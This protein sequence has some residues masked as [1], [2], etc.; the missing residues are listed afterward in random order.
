MQYSGLLFSLYCPGQ[1][2]QVFIICI[3]R[4][5]IWLGG[6]GGGGVECMGQEWGWEDVLINRRNLCI[7]PQ[8]LLVLPIVLLLKLFFLNKCLCKLHDDLMSSIIRLK[9]P[10]ITIEL[11]SQ[12]GLNDTG[13]N[14]KF[15]NSNRLLMYCSMFW[16]NSAIIGGRHRW[17][18]C[19]ILHLKVTLIQMC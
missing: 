10:F 17:T 9:T 12:S 13:W 18:I 6:G 8:G 15:I 5:I 16:Q 14:L 19:R 3:A 1:V 4:W 2:F 7:I 11:P